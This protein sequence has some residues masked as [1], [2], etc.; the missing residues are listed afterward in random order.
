MSAPTNEQTKPV[1]QETTA[2]LR[3]FNNGRAVLWS[4]LSA[5]GVV[6]AGLTMMI[7]LALVA[8]SL[9]HPVGATTHSAAIVGVQSWLLANGGGLSFGGGALSLPPLAVTGVIGYLFYRSGRSIARRCGI[10]TYLGI[11]EALIAVG[12]TYVTAAF[13]LTSVGTTSAVTIGLL[14]LGL[15]SGALSVL[16]TALGLLAESGRGQDLLH[17]LPGPSHAYLRGA[18]AGVFALVGMSALLFIASLVINFS[19]ASAMIAALGPSGTSG[20]TITVVAM[21]FLPNALVCI[22]AFSLGAGFSVGAGTHVG[23]LSVHLG[24]LPAFPL[25]A[26]MPDHP[27]VLSWSSLIAPIVA[28]IVAALVFVRHLDDDERSLTRLA[29]GVGAMALTIGLTL[30]AVALLGSGGIGA[31]RLASLGASP[32]RLFLFS[33]V[34]MAVLMAITTYTVNIKG[35]VTVL[36]ERLEERRTAAL[37]GVLDETDE[38]DDT[39]TDAEKSD[40]DA[41]EVEAPDDADTAEAD[42]AEAD[43][44]EG[45]IPTAE[46]PEVAEHR[47]TGRI[48]TAA[49]A[50]QLVQD[51]QRKAS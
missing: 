18:L 16:P 42:T 49:I 47:D 39:D 38:A 43:E 32:L 44:A 12:L 3:A 34:G 2:P 22:A 36:T 5:L 28:A 41:D 23:L 33:V 11:L 14:K 17:Q 10:D 1:E 27:S 13:L 29:R 8:W 40:I 19:A 24:P 48:D 26:V 6:L 30:G 25:F 7:A 46:V 4:A 50:A 35:V 45:V 31:D 15:V 51:R 21:L 9:D 20:L 37:E